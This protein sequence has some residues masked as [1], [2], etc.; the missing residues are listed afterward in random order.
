MFVENTASHTD[1]HLSKIK[2]S[3]FEALCTESSDVSSQKVSTFNFLAFSLDIYKLSFSDSDDSMNTRRQLN[4]HDSLS[5]S[6]FYVL[7]PRSKI[8]LRMFTLHRRW[9]RDREGWW[10]I[11]GHASCLKKFLSIVEIFRALS[12]TL[13]LLT[14]RTHMNCSWIT[15]KISF[16]A[17]KFKSWRQTLWLVKKHDKKKKNLS[18][19]VDN[20]FI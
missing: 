12:S 14:L 17:H 15:P 18:S 20:L 10:G 8:V 2:V 19:D 9:E 6:S 4:S 5:V 11:Y 7:K 1:T 3:L 16:D 13:L